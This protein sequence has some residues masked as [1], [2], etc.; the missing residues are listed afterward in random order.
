MILFILIGTQE[1]FEALSQ[2]FLFGYH[3]NIKSIQKYDRQRKVLN[4]F[5]FFAILIVGEIMKQ[6]ILKIEGM[7]CSA[8]S[9]GLEK[10][11]K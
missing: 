1:T 7:S 6:V 11:F 10:I 8:C 5:F 3:I 9:N 2:F 4:S